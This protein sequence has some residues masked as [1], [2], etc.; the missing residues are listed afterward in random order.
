MVPNKYPV[1]NIFDFTNNVT[2]SHVFSSLNLIKGYYQVE[3]L[4][5]AIPKTAII[6]PFRLFKFIRM[7]FGLR[8]AGSMFQGMKLSFSSHVP[9]HGLV[10][11]Y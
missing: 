1:P 3:M 5:N 11:F 9:P 8:K 10:N 7:P 4:L 2:G 6:M